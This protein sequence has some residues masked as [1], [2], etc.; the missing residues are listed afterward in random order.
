MFGYDLKK[1]PKSAKWYYLAA[2][3][4]IV[5]LALYHGIKDIEMPKPRTKTEWYV[6]FCYQINYIVCKR[7]CLWRISSSQHFWRKTRLSSLKATKGTS[8]LKLSC[9]RIVTQEL[10]WRGPSEEDIW[11]TVK[12]GPK[13]KGNVVFKT[14]EPPSFLLA[15]AEETAER[16]VQKLVFQGIRPDDQLKKGKIERIKTKITV[17]GEKPSSPGWMAQGSKYLQ[18]NWK[19]QKVRLVW[20]RLEYS[21]ELEKHLKMQEEK[22]FE[23]AQKFK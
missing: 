23:D 19:K 20:C 5:G 11:Q 22:R 7:G 21:K 12:D 17:V 6:P 13:D 16:T 14:A 10:H 15:I 2:Y 9:I 4:I 1:L 18:G 8:N 3:T